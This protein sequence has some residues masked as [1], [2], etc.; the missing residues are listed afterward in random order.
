MKK[1]IILFF[2]IGLTFAGFGQHPCSVVKQK[3]F[4]LGKKALATSTTVRLLKA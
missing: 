3:G 4:R 2:L 1:S